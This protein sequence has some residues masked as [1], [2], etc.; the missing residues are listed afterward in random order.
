MNNANQKLNLGIFG[1]G[2]M[3]QAIFRLLLKQRKINNNLNFFIYSLGVKQVKQATCLS[4]LENLIKKCDIIFICIKPQNFYALNKTYK[5][6][7]KIIVSIMA[8]VKMDKIKKTFPG[9]KIIRAMPNLPLLVGQGVI[10]WRAE[11]TINKE[12]LGLVK[13]IFSVFGYSLKVKTED[14]LN[15]ITALTGSGP[16]YVFLFINALIKS[17]IGLGFSPKIAKQM[18]NKLIL[19][20]LKYVDERNESLADLINQVKLKGG[21]TEAALKKINLNKFYR[22]WRN[23]IYQAYL[24][25]KELS[26]YEK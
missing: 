15:K 18:I 17:A 23:A 10:G 21:T 4:D 3:G 7:R 13:D 20:S 8:G 5:A 11:K 22:Q 6:R 16:A 14:D 2:H 24:K 1:F 19:G 25:A 9:S 26:S 12:G